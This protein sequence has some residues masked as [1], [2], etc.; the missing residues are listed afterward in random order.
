MAL[1]LSLLGLGAVVAGFERSFG[2]PGG[3]YSGGVALLI[4]AVASSDVDVKGAVK[5][6]RAERRAKRDA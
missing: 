1:V 6:K 2:I 5:R 3:L 4:A